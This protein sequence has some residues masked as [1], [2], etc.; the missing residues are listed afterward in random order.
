[1][2]LLLYASRGRS[3][4]LHEDIEEAFEA[5]GMQGRLGKLFMAIK[6]CLQ[7]SLSGPF[8]HSFHA[9]SMS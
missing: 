4:V 9:T 7:K 6:S 3:A 1:M 5:D 2:C 8:P